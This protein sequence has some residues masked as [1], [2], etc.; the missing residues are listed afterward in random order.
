MFS[1][2][3]RLAGSAKLLQGWGGE[4]GHS[5]RDTEE[6]NRF[7]EDLQSISIKQVRV[8]ISKLIEQVSEE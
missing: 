6:G 1:H 8:L 2:Q 7:L 3:N 5:Y 4:L